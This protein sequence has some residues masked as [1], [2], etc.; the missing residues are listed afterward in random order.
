[1][2]KQTWARVE[3][4]K[5]SI[6]SIDEQIADYESRLRGLKK[7]RDGMMNA[8]VELQTKPVSPVIIC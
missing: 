8:L 6:V 1:M 5:R 3:S 7:D 4:Y 2:D